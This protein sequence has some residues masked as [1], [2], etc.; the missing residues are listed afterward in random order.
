[1]KAWTRKAVPLLLF[2]LLATG[3]AACDETLEG[4]LGCAVLCPEVPLGVEQD[5]LYAV[6]LDSALGGFPAIGTEGQLMLSV[7]GDTFDARAVI[8]F[9]SLPATFRHRNSVTDSAIVYVDSVTLRFLV[10][11]VDTLGPDFTVELYDVGVETGDDT[12]AATLVPLFEPSRLIGS[13]TFVAAEVGDTLFVP[14]DSAVVRQ[15]IEATTAAARRLRV[16]ARLVASG[17]TELVVFSSNAAAAPELRMR[18]SPDTN[19]FPIHLGPVSRTPSGPEALAADLADFQLIAVA[20]PPPPGDVLRVGGLPATRAYLRF[21]VPARIVDSSSIVRAQLQ[22]VQRPNLTGP[23]ATDTGGVQAFAVASGTV[24][25]DIRRALDFLVEGGDTT[26]L[27][28]ADSGLRAIEIISVVRSWRNTTVERT[29]RAVALRSTREGDSPWL[30]DF[31]SNEAAAE[32][33][34]RLVITYVPRPTP[35]VP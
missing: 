17:S 31:Y 4:G 1:M 34:P 3:L 18:V 22:L 29:P 24:L 13:R 33:R 16:G 25:T 23:L 2:A 30:V 11:R 27:V 32:V 12:S 26:R 28:P 7:R 5:T 14:I 9:D 35:R 6:T 19:V 10:A 8:R 15:K 21:D 20:P